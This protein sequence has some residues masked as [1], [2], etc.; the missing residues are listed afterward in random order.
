LQCLAYYF[1]FCRL[2]ACL[3][4]GKIVFTARE[5]TIYAIVGCCLIHPAM[6]NGTKFL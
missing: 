2:V 3:G 5:P 6:I 1:S 4:F